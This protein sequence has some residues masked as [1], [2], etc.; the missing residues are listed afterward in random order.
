MVYNST[1]NTFAPFFFNYN[2]IFVRE[3]I[4]V[5]SAKC[6]ATADLWKK[7]EHTNVVH[8]KEIFTTKSF[9]DRCKFEYK[10]IA[11]TVLFNEYVSD[12]ALVLVYDYHPGS[13]TLL[14]KYF[15]PTPDTN[16]YTDPFQGDARPFR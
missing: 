6:M 4:Q 12:T 15:T 13:V 16:G 3:G 2:T 9:N 8:F 10:S 1:H 5:Q 11:S 7:V 14:S